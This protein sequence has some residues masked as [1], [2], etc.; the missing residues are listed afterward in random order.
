MSQNSSVIVS[1]MGVDGSGKSTLI[2]LLRKKLKNKYKKIKY[3]HLR[4]YLIF[5]NL[6]F[7]LFFNNLINVLFPEPSTP[8]KDTII[9]EF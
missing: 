7:N 9:D 5:L 4:P 2:E 8:M 1:F 3:V 6:F